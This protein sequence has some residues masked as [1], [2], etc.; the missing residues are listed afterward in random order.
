MVRKVGEIDVTE[1]GLVR[2]GD[3][4]VDLVDEVEGGDLLG[5]ERGGDL[6]RRVLVPRQGRVPVL[7][8]PKNR[9]FVH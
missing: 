1:E 7:V 6:V 3:E 2:E 5:A 8:R 4:L 9:P